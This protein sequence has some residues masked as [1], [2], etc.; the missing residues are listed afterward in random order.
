MVFANACDSGAKLIEAVQKPEGTPSFL[1]RLNAN[2]R[3]CVCGEGGN[4]VEGE[5]WGGGVGV[6]VC[7]RATCLR[8]CVCAH[9]Y[10]FLIF[11]I[12]GCPYMGVHIL[13]PERKVSASNIW[14]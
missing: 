3:H 6:F 11:L 5:G 8:A 14:Y 4:G 1:P 10:I 13:R 9:N 7:V 12:F 2:V